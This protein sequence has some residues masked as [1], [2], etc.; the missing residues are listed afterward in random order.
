M[1]EN[2][3]E[4]RLLATQKGKEEIEKR[5][6]FLLRVTSNTDKHEEQSLATK[7]AL[8]RSAVSS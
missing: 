2:S 5:K 7:S 3:N 6:F 4:Y 1:P 8:K